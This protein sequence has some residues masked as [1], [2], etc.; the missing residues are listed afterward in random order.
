MMPLVSIENVSMRYRGPMLMDDVSARI[1]PNEA[2]GL[3]GRN[4]AGKT[5]LMKI[6]A[7]EVVPDAG[8]VIV[9]PN[10][11]VR[12]LVQDVPRSFTG[13]VSD[14]V[15]ALAADDG[16][17]TDAENWEGE[18]NWQLAQRVE[19]TLTEMDLDGDQRVENLSSGW[20]RRVLL[21]GAV[22]S[23]PDLLLLD[24]PTN[25]LDIEAILWLEKFLKGFRGSLLFVTHDRTFLRNTANRIWEL[26]RG[27]LFDWA[28]DHD[29]FV[30]RKADALQ[31][32]AQQQ[33]LFDKKL[34]EEERWI[35][36]GIKARRTRNEGRVRA[37]KEMRRVR[38][39]RPR[40]VGKAKLNFT[41]DDRSG[42]LVARL[43]DVSFAYD[44]R[45]ILSGFS[46]T[47][48]RGDRVGIIGRNGAGKST[49]L[50]LLL[51]KLQP[52]SGDVRLGTHL[53]IAY[54]DQLR[55]QLD[56]ESLAMDAVADG[57]DHVMVGD[58]RKHIYGYLQDFLF[59]PERARTPVKFLSGG[60]RHRLLL[61][62]LM[63]RP[64]NLLVLDEPTNDLDFETLE[65]LEEQLI[66]FQGTLLMVSHDRSFLNS[67]VTSTIVFE[68]DT[69]AEYVGGYDEYLATKNRRDSAH[70]SAEAPAAKKDSATTA[71]AKNSTGGGR[72]AAGKVVLQRSAGIGRVAGADRNAGGRNC[73]TSQS[74]GRARLL[75]PRQGSVGLGRWAA[76][77]FAK[78]ARRGVPPLGSSRRK[79]V[80]QRPLAGRQ[81]N[82][83]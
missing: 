39:E 21:A 41:G 28:C 69:V 66:Q 5:T 53:S 37:L 10:A 7:G 73:P 47:V 42:S 26:D 2:I 68:D 3:L 22:A 48:M 30:K 11:R 58:K 20:K 55:D 82:W 67:V 36:Q 71:P 79:R 13:S 15:M 74:H 16:V 44:D 52:T 8:N 80:N 6:V 62:R 60:E 24:E 19:R 31:A 70:R 12:R 33:A 78:R 61:A 72:S 32:Q 35:R 14:V 56:A 59:T 46:T 27:R 49:L 50:K 38:G 4:G 45:T 63:C 1:E 75:P 76:I 51:G 83:S 64:A 43:D 9:D 40:E 65:L 77:G 18:A 81:S 23:A 54:F 57:A 17:D 25:H 29:T 34:A